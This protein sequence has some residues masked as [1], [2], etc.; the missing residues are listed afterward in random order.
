MPQVPAKK[1]S[2]VIQKQGFGVSAAGRTRPKHSML[3]CLS[4]CVFSWALR[5]TSLMISH[6]AARSCCSCAAASVFLHVACC[7][8]SCLLL[9]CVSWQSCACP[10]LFACLATQVI[11]L[12]VPTSAFFGGGVG[13]LCMLWVRRS[14]TGHSSSSSLSHLASAVAVTTKTTA[15]ACVLPAC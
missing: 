12:V 13:G 9:D 1:R 10:S 2:V 8:P 6:T 3:F 15:A 14:P 4:V 11:A 7:L 5:K